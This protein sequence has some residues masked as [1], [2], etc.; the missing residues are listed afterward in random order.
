M[1]TALAALVLLPLLGADSSSAPRPAPRPLPRSSIAAVLAHRGELGL[2]GA[3]VKRLEERDAVLQRRLAEI[4]DQLEAPEGR[5]RAGR[6]GR[7]PPRPPAD[8]SSP[9]P[10]LPE[11]GPGQGAGPGGGPGPRGRFRAGG[12]HGGRR[13]G[14]G[15]LAQDPAARAAELRRRL[16]DADTAAWLEAETLLRESHR[17][18]ARA[19][20]EKY[21]EDLADERDAERPSR[22]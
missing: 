18:P 9:Q 2:D 12:G 1:S 13:S 15:R 4:R 10:S 6:E 21:R 19:V 17:E 3:E 11:V 8:G 22:R 20:A 14:G 5:D 7:S 16:D